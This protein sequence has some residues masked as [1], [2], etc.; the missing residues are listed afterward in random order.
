MAVLSR[1]VTEAIMET[2]WEYLEAA[3][4]SRPRAGPA[5]TGRKAAGPS[6]Q[7]EGTGSLRIQAIHW[8]LIICEDILIKNEILELPHASCP[9]PSLICSHLHP[10]TQNRSNQPTAQRE[11]PQ[12]VSV[13]RGADERA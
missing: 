7:P 11:A 13:V 6:A 2:R 3:S 9:E 8:G 4:T 5:R 10:N 12:G 1:A